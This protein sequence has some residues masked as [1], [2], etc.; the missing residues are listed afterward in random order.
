[1]RETRIAMAANHS[2][3][4]KFEDSENPDYRQVIGN[5]RGLVEGAIKAV[6][7]RKRLQDLSVPLASL[8]LAKQCT[9][10]DICPY[11]FTNTYWLTHL[12]GKLSHLPIS[13]EPSFHWSRINTGRSDAEVPSR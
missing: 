10:Q 1:M 7:D 8:S 2:S 4:C 13:R 9:C 3:I 6:E 11:N 12:A 5:L